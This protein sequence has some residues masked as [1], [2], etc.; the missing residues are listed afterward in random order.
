MQRT[1]C[2]GRRRADATSG[3]RPGR[4]EICWS[5]RPATIAVMRSRSSGRVTPARG[6]PIGRELEVLDRGP[7]RLRRR[8]EAGDRALEQQLVA[9]VVLQAEVEED[10]AGHPEVGARIV[11]RLAPADCARGARSLPGRTGR[12]RSPPWSRSTSTATGPASRRVPRHLAARGRRPRA[13]A[14]G[15]WPLRGSPPASP[16]G[17]RIACRESE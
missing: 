5:T 8:L 11:A 9:G 14:S 15:R 4:S 13:P 2:R 7:V 17:V 12:R 3:H 6:E 16:G 10:P 1:T